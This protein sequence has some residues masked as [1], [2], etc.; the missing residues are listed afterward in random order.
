MNKEI[1]PV[2]TI[3]I[4]FLQISTLVLLLYLTTFYNYLLF[5]SLAGM[6]VAIAYISTFVVTWNSRRFLDNNFFLIIG[7]SFLFVGVLSI[8]H[9]LAYK[10]MGIF[11]IQNA[12]LTTQLWLAERY[13][14]ALS[15]VIAPFL[16]G[17]KIDIMRTFQIFLAIF[18]ILILSIFFL[19]LFPNTYT[20]AQGLTS[21]KK[22]SE[23]VITFLFLA[24]LIVIYLKRK[25]FDSRVFNLI[26]IFLVFTIISEVL[27]AFYSGVYDWINMLGH[28]FEVIAAYF[29]YLGIIESGLMKPYRTLFKNLKDNEVVLRESEERYKLLVESSPEAIL[30]HKEK[31]ILYINPTGIK[32]FG[33]KKE[34]E[35][36]GKSILEFIHPDYKE[37]VESRI[38]GLEN[39]TRKA[40]TAEMK[41]IRLDGRIIDI[42]SSGSLINYKNKPAI[43]T[44]FSDITN[45]KLA[46]EDASDHITMTDFN[47]KIIYANRAAERMTGYSKEEMMGKTPQALWGNCIETPDITDIKKCKN[48]WSKI[49]KHSP[50]FSGEVVN[51]RKNGERY[52]AELHISPVRDENS[53]IKFFISIERDVTRLKQIDHAKT[54]FISLASHQLRTPLT[55]ISLS[56][57]LLLRNQNSTLDEKQKKYVEEI[58]NS[59]KKMSELINN[60]LNISR[61]ELGTF[62]IEMKHINIEKK[63]NT[64]IDELKI[65]AEKKNIKVKKNIDEDLPIVRYDRKVFE[66]IAQNLIANAIKY[67]P[68]GGTVKITATQTPSEILMTISDTGYGIPEKQQYKIFTKSFRAENAKKIDTEGA[69]LGLYI[70]KFTAEKTGARIWFDSKEN[71]G[72]NFYFSIPIKK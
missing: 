5:H 68:S 22:I 32:F 40:P 2:T 26:T 35:I 63:L 19:G 45:R 48:V 61:I 47:G 69:G 46:I 64:I 16:I 24:S 43:Q 31:E 3:K 66:I 39:R 72:S 44:I 65:Q 55:G 17:K 21:F 42:E 38:Q 27:F 53:K 70:A 7:I 20:D 10:E 51:Q 14:M 9:V 37:L 4:A 33:A 25:E 8:F 59:S 58:Y 15:F 52:I 71:K 29:L 1:Y 30:V 11:N 28:V 57:E 67:T 23:G 12:N 6:V 36:L 41:L 56:A 54:E 50:F 13:M 18:T 60:L 62:L 49:T 34:D